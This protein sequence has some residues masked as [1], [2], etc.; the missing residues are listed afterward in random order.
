MWSQLLIIQNL[1]NEIFFLDENNLSI[2]DT[3]VCMS[4]T[5]LIT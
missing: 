4:Q 5:C 3:D 1:L 2:I